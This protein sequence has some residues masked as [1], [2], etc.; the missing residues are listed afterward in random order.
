[1]DYVWN[2]D[3]MIIFIKIV[4]VFV[5]DH[6]PN[7][8][9]EHD[10]QTGKFRQRMIAG[11]YKRCLACAQFF[12]VKAEQSSQ[13]LGTVVTQCLTATIISELNCFDEAAAIV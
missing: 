11:L 12:A 6:E 1:M 2:A 7:E 10:P 5:F 8:K 13:F 3:G 4:V 9:R